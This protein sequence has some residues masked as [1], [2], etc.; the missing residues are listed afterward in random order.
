MAKIVLLVFCTL[1]SSV[2]MA[3]QSRQECWLDNLPGTKNDIVAMQIIKDCSKYDYYP[4]EKSDGWFG[5]KTVSWCIRKYGEDTV[6]R[7]AA[8]AIRAACYKLYKN[9]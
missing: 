6:S 3:E 9:E 5:G 8:M 2:V 7:Q 1:F 4:G